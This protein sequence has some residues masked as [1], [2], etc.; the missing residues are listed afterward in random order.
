VDPDAEWGPHE[1]WVRPL[2]LFGAGRRDEALAALH[3]LPDSSRDLLFEA[4]TCLHAL[5]AAQ[6]DDRPRMECLY[7]QLL[8]AAGELA[9]AGS[10]L[11]TLGPDGSPPRPAGRRPRPAGPGRRAPRRRTGPRR[12]A[13]RAALGCGGPPGTVAVA[14]ST[15]SAR[16]DD[17]CRSWGA[18][19]CA[20]EAARVELHVTSRSIGPRPKA[21]RQAVATTVVTPM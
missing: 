18:G 10:G 5:A 6:A 7:A 1:P 9:G 15:V 13:R 8:P 20:G 17:G 2:T 16:Q 19:G 11:L 3:D 4:R 21:S 14:R 12:P